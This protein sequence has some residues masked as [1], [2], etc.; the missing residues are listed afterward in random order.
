MNTLTPNSIPDV[1]ETGYFAVYGSPPSLVH[2][3]KKIGYRSVVR[4]PILNS[5][6]GAGGGIIERYVTCKSCQR[7]ML[8]LCSEMVIAR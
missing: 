2:V 8:K 4:E 1:F 6:N 5:F 3:T 7:L